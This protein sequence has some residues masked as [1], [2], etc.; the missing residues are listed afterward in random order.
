MEINF[1]I[2]WKEWVAEKKDLLDKVSQ[3]LK[4]IFPNSGDD[5]ITFKDNSDVHFLSYKIS[6]DKSEMVYLK[7]MCDYSEAKAAIILSRVKDK[8]CN[9]SHRG[10]YSIICT[11]DEASLSF[12]CR[13]MKPLGIF[14]RRLRQIMYLTTV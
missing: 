7:I 4:D 3:M 11:Y 10:D 2:F 8:I 6:S 1:M 13:L 5:F 9:G 12:C 14:E